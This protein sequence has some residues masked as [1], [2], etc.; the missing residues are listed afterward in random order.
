MSLTEL[1]Q[2]F[3]VTIARLF[4][5][6]LRTGVV[7]IKGDI[8]GGGENLQC[9]SSRQ[10]FSN[11]HTENPLPRTG[12]LLV[13]SVSL[14][15][16]LMGPTRATCEELDWSIG[17]YGGQYYDTEPANFAHSST[18][19]LEQYIVALTAST[20]VWRSEVLPLSLEMDGMVGQQFGLSS[21]SEVAVAPVLRWSAFPWNELLQ[22]DFRFGPL[23]VSYTTDVSPLERGTNGKGSR[24]LN[25]LVIELDFSLPQMRS[26]EV[27][28]RLH[29][30]CT[31]YDLLN[32]YGA[33]GEDFL[34][35]GYR[36]YF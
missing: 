16:F 22:T 6:T 11:G 30:R 1:R 25:F 23:G 15:V 13:L 20:A 34:T 7:R 27:F 4:P 2:L 18:K 8:L 10:K 31:I 17:W 26:K 24:T 5:I 3:G 33:N 14:S 9:G 35:F 36:R 19:Y 29:H 21:L 28:M 12:F 32:D